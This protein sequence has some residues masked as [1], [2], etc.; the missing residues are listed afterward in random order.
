[1]RRS[2]HV[3]FDDIVIKLTPDGMVSIEQG[4]G[5]AGGSPASDTILFP[6]EMSRDI[7]ESIIHEGTYCEESVNA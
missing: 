7:A 4:R 3:G 2:I 5:V 6:A 1:M